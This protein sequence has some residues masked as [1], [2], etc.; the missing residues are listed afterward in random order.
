MTL[1][2]LMPEAT[3]PMTTTR[4]MASLRSTVESCRN[5]TLY[6]TPWGRRVQGLSRAASPVPR[7]PLPPSSRPHRGR[8]SAPHRSL[9]RGVAGLIPRCFGD[10]GTSRH[11]RDPSSRSFSSRTPSQAAPLVTPTRIPH[12]LPVLVAGAYRRS[13]GPRS[14]IERPPSPGRLASGKP[15]C[16]TVDTHR[17]EEKKAALHPRRRSRRGISPQE[18]SRGETRGRSIGRPRSPPTWPAALARPTP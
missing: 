15:G 5:R 2:A 8:P 10:F 3:A 11:P 17:H 9:T 1:A 18:D 13:F 12:P 14:A 4:L 16:R 6:Y 7:P